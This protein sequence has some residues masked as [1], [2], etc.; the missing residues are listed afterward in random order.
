MGM[1]AEA[2]A[3]AAIKREKNAALAAL[4]TAALG[5]PGIEAQAVT[6]M[7][8]AQGNVM[9]GHYQESG[10]R[11][12]V[13]VYHGDFVVPITDRLEFSYSIDRDTYSGAT[14]AYSMPVTMADQPKYQ[15]KGDGPAN[16]PTPADVVSAASGGLSGGGMTIL[17]GLNGFKAFQD[18]RAGAE[19]EF[20]ANNP[21]PPSP[22]PPPSIAGEAI[23]TFSGMRFSSYSGNPNLAP[24]AG[25]D[26]P[27]RGPSGCFNQAGMVIGTPS[28][29]SV[30]TNPHVHR[31]GNF[32]DARLAYHGD[33]AGIYIRALNS[34]AFALTSLDFLA[35]ITTDNPNTPASSWDIIGFNTALNPNLTSIP[36]PP[37]QVASQS[38]PNGFNGTL[39]LDNTFQ[40]IN[41]FWIH[42]KGYPQTPTDGVAFQ[43]GVDNVKLTGVSP[44]TEKTAEQIAWEQEFSKQVAI[45][46]YRAVL[47]TMV[48]AN[49]KIVQRFQQQPLETRNMPVFGAKYYLE[50][51]ILGFSGGF[52]DEPDFH[53]DFGNANFT[54]ELNDKHTTLNLGLNYTRNQITRSTDNVAHGSHHASDPAHNPITYDRLNENSTFYGVNLSLSQVVSKN[55]LVQ[56][57]GNFTNQS[58]YL[59][60]PYKYVYIRGEVTAEE[61]YAIWQTP[62]GQLNIKDY[63][64]LEMVGTELY[65]E[66]RPSLRNMG[67]ISLGVSQHIPALNAS[68]NAD[69]RFYSDSWG[70]DSNTFE[71]KWYQPLPFGIMVTPNIRYYSQ[72]QADFFAPYFLEPRDDGFYSSDFRLSDYGSLSGGLT[73]SK[74]FAKGI[75][76]QAGFE[77]YTHA[78]NLKL[79]GGGEDAYADY[80]YYLVHAGLNFNLSAPA[81]IDRG[82]HHHHHGAQPPAGV[83]FAHM[84]PQADDI[85][86]GYRYMYSEQSGDMLHGADTVNIETLFF[87]G[88][89]YMYCLSRPTS[90]NMHMHMFEL[91]YAPTDWLNLMV[92]P[93][94]MDMNMETASLFTNIEDVHNGGHTSQGLGD[95]IMMALIKVF[96]THGHHVHVGIGMSAPTGSVEVTMDGRNTQDSLYQD[97]GMQLGSGTWD[98]KPNLTYTGQMDDFS[99]GLQLSGIMRM[100]GRNASNYALGDVFQTTAWGGYHPFNWFTATVRGMY[101][102]QG[103]IRGAFLHAHSLSSPV[104]FPSNYGGRF[105]DVGF[106][107]NLSAPDTEFA[108]H[109]LSVEWLQPVGTDFNG[110]QVERTGSLAATWTYSF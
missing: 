47:N 68:V 7:T 42:Y 51:S 52:S 1:A 3:V 18:A 19:A 95:T 36:S 30:L 57:T 94:I 60:N 58:G 70:I 103:A 93:Q 83:M 31:D 27:T 54:R 88:C 12:Q 104:D 87:Q 35:P 72:S 26:C 75:S 23:L 56:M 45:A 82:H 84:M 37:T 61:Y 99:W 4:T 106:G 15:L 91:M 9:Y 108:G 105:W 16:I 34:A 25:G 101:T 44:S 38:V 11:M 71:L 8:E 55:T 17:G 13:D 65:R 110:Y 79:G 39:T 40:N 85:M 102:A 29:P 24:D 14:P 67:S 41:A 22:P 90:M 33:S 32:A 10:N 109:N 100:E 64:Q 48:P 96:D 77:Y 76:L 43:M 107:M 89:E 74:K 69:Y 50:N 62:G 81:P 21:Y 2:V 92:M 97:Y 86:V 63:T 98:F 49:T 59:T 28:D 80:S 66:N 73:I 20:K 78:G 6:A 53:S 5:L 46:Q